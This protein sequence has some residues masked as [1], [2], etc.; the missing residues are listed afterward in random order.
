[1]LQ[2]ETTINL[3]SRS[4]L[5]LLSLFPHQ[6]PQIL[7]W[8]FGWGGFGVSECSFWMWLRRECIVLKRR[9]HISHTCSSENS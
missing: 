9:A 1:M 8:T 4:V 7:H 3:D 6:A 5:L 2:P